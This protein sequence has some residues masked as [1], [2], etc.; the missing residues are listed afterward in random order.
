MPCLRREDVAAGEERGAARE[1]KTLTPR[2][3]QAELRAVSTLACAEQHHD[4]DG[5]LEQEQHGGEGDR[6]DDPDDEAIRELPSTSSRTASTST[7]F[8]HGL[9]A[10]EPQLDLL[11]PTVSS[12]NSPL[13]IHSNSIPAAQVPRPSRMQT[14]CLMACLGSTNLGPCP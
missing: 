7:L 10:S 11:E 1:P 13:F 4:V 6:K 14:K 5:G 3:R 2:P 9:A 8:R 12:C